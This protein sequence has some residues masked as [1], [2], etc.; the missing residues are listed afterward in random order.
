ME[1]RL[2]ETRLKTTSSDY[3]KYICEEREYLKSL[4]KERP[5]VNMAAEYLVLLKKLEKATYVICQNVPE[6]SNVMS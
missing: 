4:K 1:L 2:L 6:D 3:E 5:E